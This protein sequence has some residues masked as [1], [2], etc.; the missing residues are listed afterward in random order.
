MSGIVVFMYHAL[1]E[2]EAEYRSLDVA[3]R[4]YAVR[5]REFEA[6][7]DQLHER[8]IPILAPSALEDQNPPT[9]GVVLTFD[10]GHGSDHAYAFPAL[11]K[12][13]LRGVFFVTTDFI[14]RRPGFC[15]WTGLRA[16]VRA[17]M[18]IGSHGRTHSFLD[19]LSEDEA[20]AELEGSRRAIEG[21]T[22]ARVTTVSFPGGRFRAGQLALAKAAGYRL[23]FSSQ[24][25]V[26]RP[27]RGRRRPV[28][29]IPVRADTPIDLY[30]RFASADPVLLARAQVAYGFKRL[31]KC[32]IGNRLYHAIYE[33]FSV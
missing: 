1:Y 13:G 10:D 9:K 24:I 5:L 11:A 23:C 20:R 19:D 18:V 33:R 29:R 31:A 3:D 26:W 4:P 16:M 21:E 25:G 15:D 7:L 28:P 12:R 2:S 14:G 30:V 17:G 27:T 6:H 32:I 22:G 8:G